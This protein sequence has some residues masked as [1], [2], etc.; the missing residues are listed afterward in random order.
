MASDPISK[1]YERGRSF[2]RG[3]NSEDHP[4]PQNPASYDRSPRDGALRRNTPQNVEDSADHSPRFAGDTSARYHNDVDKK[5]WLQSGRATDRPGFDYKNAYRT[6]RNTG[7]TD[8]V[9]DR[10]ADHNRHWS[11]F[12]LHGKHGTTHSV[13]AHDRSQRHVPQYERTGNNA[14]QPAVANRDGG[15]G[16]TQ[17]TISEGLHNPRKR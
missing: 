4:R 7:M 6:D 14:K 17:R 2:P 16:K 10:P 11:E 15:E 9:K 12:Q 8:Q 1:L 3:R 5:S 13:D